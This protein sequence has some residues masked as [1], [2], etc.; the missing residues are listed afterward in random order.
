MSNNFLKIAAVGLAP[1]TKAAVEAMGVGNTGGAFGG[2]WYGLT[3]IRESFGGAFQSNITVDAPRNLLAFS[4]V[5][6]PLTLIANDVAKLDLDLVQEDDKGICSPVPKNSPYWSVLR[7]PNNFQN[8]IQFIE[9]WILSK[10]L[11]GNVYALKM[12]DN[13]GIVTR[14]TILDPQ[15]VTPLV[16]IEG[17][18]YYRLSSDHLAGLQGEI[19]VPASEIIHDRMNCFW[20]PLVGISPL[21][22][23]AMSA[24]MGNKIQNNSASFFQNMSRPS[25]MLTAPGT[26]DPETAARLKREFEENFGGSNV[27]RLAVAGD[28]LEYLAMNVP[29]ATAQLIEQLNWTVVDVA[30]CFH[31]P[32][33]KVGA[34]TGRNAGTMSVEALQQSYLND[35]LQIYIES[36]EACLTDGL[37]LP[38]NYEVDCDETGLLR[39]D[40]AARYESLGVAIKGGMM[41]PNEARAKEGLA[42]VDGGDECYLQMQNFSLAAL[43]KRDAK[44][45][46]FGTQGAAPAI[47]TTSAGTQQANDAQA[48]KQA[49]ELMEYISKGLAC[50]T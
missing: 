7:K 15:R 30:R 38:L 37:G 24:T 50:S 26:I 3:S 46:P 6:A 33:F 49:K 19:T 34:E 16:T 18:V 5:F 48:A 21:F 31:M 1:R 43:A 22:A 20:H 2:G 27:G 35:C 13:R 8:K 41:K 11:H 36:L 28:G 42:P 25:G 39:M 44:D 17:D 10:L 47:D 9:N 45:D 29:A 40:T 4:G 32:L 12:R 23:A 14:L